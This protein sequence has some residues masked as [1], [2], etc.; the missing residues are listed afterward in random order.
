MY[1]KFQVKP[2]FSSL[3]TDQTIKVFLSFARSKVIPE[4][5]FMTSHKSITTQ[6]FRHNISDERETFSPQTTRHSIALFS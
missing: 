5:I 6:T 2:S 1:T 3:V 4:L